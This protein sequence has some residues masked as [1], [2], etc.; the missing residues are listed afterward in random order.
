M[1]RTGYGIYYALGNANAGLRD[2]LNSSNGFIAAPVFQ[3]LDAGV[4]AAFNWDR[5]F[6]QNFVQPPVI[7]PSA[8]NGAEIRLI[9]KGDGRAPY[10]Q[11]W[12]MT[13]EREI[14][15]RVNF[16]IGYLGTKGSRLGTALVRSNELSPDLLRLGSLLTRP[17]NSA[18]AIAAG[19][20]SPYPGFTGSVAQ[21]LRPYPQYNNL[22]NRADPN[23]S[24]TYHSLQ[25]QLTVRAAKGFDVLASYT[26]AKTISDSDVLAGGGQGGQTTFNRGLEKAIAITDIPH[27]FNLSYSYQ[28][29]FG[30]GQAFLRDGGVMGKVV[31]GWVFTGIHQYATGVPIILTANNSL[32]LFNALLRP[33]V[34]AGA[35][36]TGKQENFDPAV[37][38]WINPAAFS[39]PGALTFGTSARSHTSLR[40][41][42]GLNENFGLLKKIPLW[43]RV[44]LTFRAEMFN[45]FNRVV[46][47]GPQ[48][49]VSNAAFGR[50]SAQ[51]NTPR[52]GQMALRLDF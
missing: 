31:G 34:A 13:I 5:G 39:V 6:P 4:T 32:P 35:T 22:L 23:G 8:A 50:I 51:A 2:S 40:N 9:A 19:I 15:N 14:V 43:E 48:A 36:L 49:N 42:A 29:P 46:F 10:F 28:L 1:V 16:E 27:V 12:T 38:R 7:S 24:S 26:W 41:P 47:S 11:N 30:P 33:N 3:S 25:T 20:T 18:E 52:Q 45:A 17:Y 21:A 44:T 37:D